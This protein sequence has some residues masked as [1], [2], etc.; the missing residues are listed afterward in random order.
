VPRV[1]SERTNWIIPHSDSVG[2]GCK[3]DWAMKMPNAPGLPPTVT[4]ATTVF[5]AVSRTETLAPPKFA[6]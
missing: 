4:V 6:T 3:N 2:T 1:R 5:V